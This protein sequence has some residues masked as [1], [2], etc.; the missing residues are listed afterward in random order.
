MFKEERI[1]TL[2]VLSAL[3]AISALTAS[4]IGIV[5]PDIYKPIV[6]FDAMSFIFIQD[7]IS[8]AAAILLLIITLF[9]KKENMKL[10]IFR[11]ALIG[12]MFYAYGMYVLGSLYNYLYLLYQAIFSLSIFYFINAFTGIEYERL[13]FRM[14]KSLRLIIAVFCAVTPVVFAP[15]WIS[16]ILEWTHNGLRPNGG[17]FNFFVSLPILG[18]CFI[19]PVF[20]LSSIFLFRKKILGVL[21]SGILLIKFITLFI[22]VSLGYLLQPLF[23][24]NTKM[25]IFNAILYS[26]IV[27][28]CMVLSIFYF[29]N[30]KVIKTKI[31]IEKII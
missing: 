20:V 16:L 25:D 21:L 11:T 6:L 8:V 22:A 19:I 2:K 7:L 3:I 9:G 27:F 31:G 10:D 17:N 29:I 12:Y 28:V 30:T 4:I 5:Y 1:I 26:V 14:P 24:N 15:Q 13:E 23:Q 18:L